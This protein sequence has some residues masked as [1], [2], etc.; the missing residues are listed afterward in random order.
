MISCRRANGKNG[1]SASRGKKGLISLW[2]IFEII[3]KY[4]WK[5][6]KIFLVELFQI[7]T[8]EFEYFQKIC[9]ISGHK[10]HTIFTNLE[11]HGKSEIRIFRGAVISVQT[12]I[13][14]SNLISELQ[15]HSRSK[16]Q[17]IMD[18]HILAN[19][20]CKFDLIFRISPPDKARLA[21]FSVLNIRFYRLRRGMLA[22]FF[23]EI[24]YL[25]DSRNHG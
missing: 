7:W 24:F 20:T 11:N 23:F 9:L 18:F 12:R 1:G 4:W 14:C 3:G 25:A 5:S 21:L 8:E 19:F 13:W 16:S 2:G 15:I 22:F 6:M 10:A 17:K